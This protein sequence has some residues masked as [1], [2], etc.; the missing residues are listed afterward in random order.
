VFSPPEA[1]DKLTGAEQG[2]LVAKGNFILPNPNDRI[3]TG[4]GRVSVHAG[5]VFLHDDFDVGP[6][7]DF[8]VYLA[9]AADTRSGGQAI[10][11]MFVDLGRLR[12]FKG[13]QKYPVPVGVDL[14]KSRAGDLV[15]AILGGDLTGRPDL[16][17]GRLTG[18]P[19]RA[20]RPL[21]PA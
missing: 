21:A 10:N 19:R 4:K 12:A 6:G 18:G 8:Y 2:T 1:M 14:T 15:S 16:R 17:A 13:S 5:T 9:P 7:P 3:R 20:Y 11:T